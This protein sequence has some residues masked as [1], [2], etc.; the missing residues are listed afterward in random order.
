MLLN[1]YHVVYLHKDVKRR[2]QQISPAGN[3]LPQPQAL[4]KSL[5]VLRTQLFDLAGERGG[6]GKARK[7][8]LC[9]S[10]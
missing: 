4:L 5:S 1:V 7:G 6:E 9:L 2:G 10:R 8:Q 3:A